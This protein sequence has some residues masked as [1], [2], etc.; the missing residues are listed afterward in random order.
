[1]S[2]WCAF[3]KERQTLVADIVT[4]GSVYGG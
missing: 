3:N 1:M 4:R 2:R